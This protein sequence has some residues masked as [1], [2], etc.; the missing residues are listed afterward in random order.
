MKLI[1]KGIWNDFGV[2]QIGV[3]I[4]AINITED[5]EKFR[6]LMEQIGVPMMAPQATATSFLKG[7]E[8]AQEFGFPCVLERPTRWEVGCSHCI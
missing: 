2:K 3:D 4:N 5:R 6:E 7:K 1:R 8:I